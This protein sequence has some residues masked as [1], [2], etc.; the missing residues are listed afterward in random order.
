MLSFYLKGLKK[1]LSA[2]KKIFIVVTVFFAVIS[3]FMYFINQDKQKLNM[4]KVDPV[5]KNREEIY[6]VIKDP[7][8]NK[9]KEGKL[10]IAVYRT[11]MC[12]MVG[13]SCTDNPADGDKRFQSSIFG[14]M[15]KLL[16]MPYSRAPASGI[17]WVYNGLAD[18]GFIT[19]SFAAQ[20]IG[21]A[22]ISPLQPIW[23]IF[24]DVSYVFLVLV[25]VA[26]GFMIMFRMK[27]NPQTVISVEN[28]LPK[29]IIS[30]LLITFSFPIAGFLIDLMYVI[31]ALSISIL[32]PA[33]A[34]KMDLAKTQNTF[35]TATPAVLIDQLFPINKQS[36]TIGPLT[37]GGSLMD[38]IQANGLGQIWF[39][40]VGLMD[41]GKTFYRILPN[42]LQG[43]F[44]ILSGVG[45]YITTNHLVT[46]L[47]SDGGPISL[48]KDVGV[49]AATFG[50]QVG[51]IF[52][53]PGGFII[54]IFLFIF[55][56]FFA[57]PLL[58]GLLVWF[59]I[60]FLF[61]RIF[62]L[63]LSTYIKIILFIIFA[64]IL[65]IFHAIPGRDTFGWWFKNLFGEIITFPLVA[66]IILTGNI[67][68]N[69][70][71]LSGGKNFWAPPF[72]YGLNQNAFSF[73]IGLG[74]ILLIPE[75][76][77]LVKELMGIKPLPISIGL[78]TFFA[79]AGAVG[80]GTLGLAGQYGS[81]AIAFP[82]LKKQAQ[83][84][85]KDVPLLKGLLGQPGE[86]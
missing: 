70:I 83:T 42:L 51:K 85:F 38:I 74:I 18:S 69:N 39:G 61:F 36:L 86:P 47:A 16:A 8:M 9:T 15:S 12:T 45:S 57:V 7:E 41:V 76:V 11:M 10:A 72:L 21:F 71:S 20:G 44:F 66:I 48:L 50:L 62:F 13:E 28:A 73:L 52:S 78:G 77:K 17:S 26:I 37:I 80:G 23:K 46:Y 56:S 54:F 35:L 27:I 63:L 53:G 6:K 30:L 33:S 79:G 2:L 59:T 82:G 55:L 40:L 25:L 19:K 75:L 34:V 43:L 3:L 58:I 65:L 60:L 81:L 84:M 4:S 49:T 29:I 64:P 24:R 67:I 68:I 32:V 22:A 1:I 5:K 31:I 14:Y